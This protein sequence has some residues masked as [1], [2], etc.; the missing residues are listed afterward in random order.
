MLFSTFFSTVFSFY[1]AWNSID[2]ARR[3]SY[4]SLFPVERNVTGFVSDQTFQGYTNRLLSVSVAK[5]IGSSL[6]IQSW[7]NIGIALLCLFA[8]FSNIAALIRWDNYKFSNKAVLVGWVLSF[9]APM[10]MS[11][12]PTRAFLDREHLDIMQR[13][14]TMEFKK[15]YHVDDRIEQS[16]TACTNAQGIDAEASAAKVIDMCNKVSKLDWVPFCNSCKQ[17]IAKCNQIRDLINTGKIQDASNQAKIVCNDVMTEISNIR[18]GNPS[19]LVKVIETTVDKTKLALELGISF[20]SALYSFKTI[21]PASM[22]LAPGLIRG[23][24]KAKAIVPQSSIPGMFIIILPWLYCPLA[25]SIYQF[26]YQMIG[27]LWVLLCVIIISYAPMAYFFVGIAKNITKPMNENQVLGVMKWIG[28]YS[29]LCN[30]I[31]LAAACY[32]IFA[33]QKPDYY[34]YIQTI[35][36]GDIKS[37][38]EIVFSTL[39]KYLFTGMISNTPYCPLQFITISF[40]IPVHYTSYIILTYSLS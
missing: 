17:A 34:K 13:Q 26:V 6:V 32:F 5:M 37:V 23:A 20:L 15:E 39:T 38:I 12:F 22:S 27:N 18:G 14:F 33:E 8:Y 3:I 28:W 35:D 21:L 40:R 11:L 10:L 24:L 7:L 31:A 25:W 2:F 19:E 9:I 16:F 4:A 29:N 1:G 30:A 36:L